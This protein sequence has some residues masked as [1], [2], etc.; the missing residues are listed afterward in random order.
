MSAC[1]F[2]HDTV[3]TIRLGDGA[4]LQN[5]YPSHSHVKLRSGKV[6]RIDTY[7]QRF[8]QDHKLLREVTLIKEYEYNQWARTKPFTEKDVSYDGKT[9]P[10]ERIESR[11]TQPSWDTL[12]TLNP[13]TTLS[14]KHKI[15]SYEDLVA[16]F[17]QPK[18]LKRLGYINDVSEIASRKALTA[19]EA[20]ELDQPQV[21]TPM[22]GNKKVSGERKADSNGEAE[23]E[24]NSAD[25]EEMREDGDEAD[26]VLLSDDEEYTNDMDEALVTSVVL[27]PERIPSSRRSARQTLAIYSNNDRSVIG[28]RSPCGKVN[29]DKPDASVVLDADEAKLKMGKTT[30]VVNNVSERRPA[31][32]SNELEADRLLCM[33]QA[34]SI[35]RMKSYKLNLPHVADSEKKFVPFSQPVCLC[36]KLS[37]ETLNSFYSSHVMQHYYSMNNGK[38]RCKLHGSKSSERDRT[39]L[40]SL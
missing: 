3:A 4:I 30:P 11:Y 26:E 24:V 39:I 15:F 35:R 8:L 10:I 16:K 34:K 17:S 18:F 6:E 2:D 9:I 22:V 13:S 32:V 28:S 1:S 31:T 14:T 37:K 21:A 25:G 7:T 19:R 5:L 12:R 27:R 23:A 20:E 38:I 36:P 29:E 40:K 33:N